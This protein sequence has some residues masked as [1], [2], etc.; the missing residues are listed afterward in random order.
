MKLPLEPALARPALPP[1]KAALKRTFDLGVA[2]AL[3]PILAPAVA[4]LALGAWRSTGKGIFVQTRIG[5]YG[6]PFRLYKICSMR[7]IEGV[8]TNVTTGEDPRITRFGRFIRRAKMDEFPQLWNVIKGDM[9]FV[10]P[11]PD[12]AEM[13][14]ALP[15]TDAPVLCLRPGITGPASVAYKN[16]EEL[17]AAQPNPEGYNAEVLFPAKMQINHAYIRDWS[18]GGDMKI[19]LGTVLG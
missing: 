11:R 6:R 3:A 8:T 1:G 4:V 2:L 17:L 18:L 14:T 13:Y 9:S 16:E 19:M 10:G 5:R 15:D 12:V 7:P